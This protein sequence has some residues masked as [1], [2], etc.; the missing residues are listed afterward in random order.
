MHIFDSID[1]HMNFMATKISQNM[2]FVCRNMLEECY[3]ITS[4]YSERFLQLVGINS[5]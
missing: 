3:Q 2:A 4:S 1:I 5:A